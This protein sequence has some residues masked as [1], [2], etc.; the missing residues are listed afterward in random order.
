MGWGTSQCSAKRRRTKKEIKGKLMELKT[1]KESELSAAAKQAK[2]QTTRNLI[3]FLWFLLALP[4]L[5]AE[6][7]SGWAVRRRTTQPKPT[8]L[9]GWAWKASKE[10][11]W[12]LRN[13]SLLFVLCGAST[14]TL[15]ANQRFAAAQTARWPSSSA[16]LALLLCCANSISF[17]FH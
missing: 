10:L 8:I 12:L 2:Q 14:T 1:N 11:V 9:C 13:C 16:L 7:A 15:H 17:S 4:A 5:S 3:E 6:E